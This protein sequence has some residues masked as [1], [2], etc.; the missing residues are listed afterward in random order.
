MSTEIE[1]KYLVK[2]L[3][4]RFFDYNH[5]ELEQAYTVLGDDGSE[6]RVRLVRHG[7]RE[8]YFY[9]EKSGGTLSRTEHELEI[10]KKEYKSLSAKAISK[11]VKKARYY[12][13]LYGDTLVAELDLYHGGL[14]GLVTVEVEFDSIEDSNAFTAPDWFGEEI[15]E[16]KRY[17]NKNLARFGKPE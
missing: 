17:K 3:P 1:R 10:T 7:D 5:R 9:T 12:I 14:A 16:D 15:T 8:R 6:V 13:P 4:E 11:F 2:Y